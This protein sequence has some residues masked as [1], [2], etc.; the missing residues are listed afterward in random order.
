[1]A[2]TQQS[3][4]LRCCSCLLFQAHQVKKSLKWT[5]KACGEK[6]SFL[7]AYG[8]GS[9]ADCR[10]H[11]QKLNL[12][13]GQDSELSLRSLEEVVSA[14]GK[15]NA[16]HPQAENWSLQ[17]RPRLSESRWL[18][19]LDKSCAEQEW[20]GG[21]LSPT[22]SS[23]STEQPGP[24]LPP[25]LPRKRKWSQN[26][27]R[28]PRSPGVQDLST[29][30]TWE[31]HEGYADLMGTEQHGSGPCLWGSVPGHTKEL[32]FPRWK[33]PSPTLQIKALSSKWAR[34]LPSTG[35]SSHVDTEPPRPLQ[36]DPMPAGPSQAKRRAPGTE[37]PREVCLSR[38][39]TVQLLQATHIPTSRPERPS[40]KSPEQLW[41]IETPQAEGRPLAQG[42]QT[43]PPIRLCDL[44]T[45][46]EDF[47]DDL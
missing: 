1:M 14:N 47:E 35:N 28:P 11:V 12:L 42:A 34:F 26:T 36:G 22:Q 8:E 23:A 6:Q 40:R 18:K 41:G 4:V 27:Q 32:S 45:T 29:G 15:E 17:G 31:P 21:E 19:Y 46:G 44:F 39:P 25:A 43:A 2:P 37:T 10:R 9:G 30:T 38:P 3:R 33:L 24:P 5:C 16:G 13:Q 20:G 7:R